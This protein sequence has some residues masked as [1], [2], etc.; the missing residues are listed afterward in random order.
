MDVS[1]RGNLPNGSADRFIGSI[2]RL[3][4]RLKKN[5]Q[6]LEILGDGK[7]TKPYIYVS[8]LVEAILRFK[9]TGQQY[10]PLISVYRGSGCKEHL[11]HPESAHT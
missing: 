4:A 9:E 6:R 3:P 10:I 11:R 7:Q 5:P 1:P 2:D 8:D